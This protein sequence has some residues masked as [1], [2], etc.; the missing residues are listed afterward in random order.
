VLPQP[1]QGPLDNPVIGKVLRSNL[2]LPGGNAEQQDR[3]NPTR[4]DLIDLAVELLID[5]EM[6][7]AGHR[8][9][10][11]LYPGAMHDEEGLDE[12]RRS[13]LVLADELS[14]GSRPA[15]APG[16]VGR[17]EG[18]EGRL[19]SGR[20]ARNGTTEVAAPIGTCFAFFWTRTHLHAST[21]RS[22]RV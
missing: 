16:S 4:T 8:G 3:R 2:V 19:E 15:A 13:K 10:L 6:K 11:T 9:D 1:A 14:Y 22:R 18:H 20:P 12:I 17:G 21:F 5:R 7:H